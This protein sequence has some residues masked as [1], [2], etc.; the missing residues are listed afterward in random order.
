MIG[1]LFVFLCSGI[2]GLVVL[3]SP[4]VPNS[5]AA[6]SGLF[7]ASTG[8]LGQIGVRHLISGMNHLSLRNN[9]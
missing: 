9:S 6:F 8:I 2:Y 1:A 3:G 4:L 7:P 5:N